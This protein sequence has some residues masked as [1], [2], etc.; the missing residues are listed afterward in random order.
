[1]PDQAML[2][3]LK[4]RL[5]EP[6]KCLP[7]CAQIPSMTVN[8][9]PD[10]IQIQL[11]IHAQEAVAVPLP[12]QLKQWFPEQIS[13]DGQVAQT[14]IRQDDG[15]LWLSLH[16]GVH[17]VLLQGR[18]SPQ[19]KFTLPLP[20][21]PQQTQVT[22]DGWRVDG[23]YENGKVGPQLEFSRLNAAPS[24][25]SNHLPQANLPAFVRVERTLQLGL[26]W[27]LH[28]RV[29]KLAGND[30]PVILELP[31]LAGEAVTSAHMR[32]KDGKL[33]I[34]VPAGQTTLE[35]QSLLEKSTCSTYARW[36]NSWLC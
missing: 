13:V 6:P 7:S 36:P 30:S 21:Q 2:E 31:L 20:L 28:T 19:Y 8:I 29:V 15:T 27:R 33:L 35:W 32:I 23:V 14:L 10:S 18:H 17:Q 22:S 12:A 34:N 16:A 9:K 25:S 5:L 1:M 4:A 3:Q 26:D 11:T 24:E